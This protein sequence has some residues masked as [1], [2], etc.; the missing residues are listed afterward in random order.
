VGL[1]SPLAT[2]DSE[3]PVGTVA[4]TAESPWKERIENNRNVTRRTEHEAGT[5]R[6]KTTL[7]SIE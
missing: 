7:L 5:D 3:K 4:A 6:V 1:D 2:N